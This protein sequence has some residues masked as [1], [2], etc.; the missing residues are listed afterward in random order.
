MVMASDIINENYF[1][2]LIFLPQGQGVTRHMGPLSV[3]LKGL[4]ENSKA[5]ESTA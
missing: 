3:T 2:K 4:G 1:F 5:V